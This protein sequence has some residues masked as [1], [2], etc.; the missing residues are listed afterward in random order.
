MVA[1]TMNASTSSVSSISGVTALTTPMESDFT[2]AGWTSPPWQIPASQDD[3]ITGLTLDD[4]TNTNVGF[5]GN[6]TGSVANLGLVNE[7]ITANAQ[8]ATGGLAGQL[9]GSIQNVY[10][11]GVVTDGGNTG[12][13][14]GAQSTGVIEDTISTASL[15]ASDGTAGGLVGFQLGGTVEYS[16]AT[17]NVSGPAAANGGLLGEQDGSN[18]H[19]SDSYATGNVSGGRVNGGVVGDQYT[20]GSIDNVYATGTVSGPSSGGIAGYQD[21]YQTGIQNAVYR[22]QSTL[23][24]IGTPDCEP[25]NGTL[26]SATTSQMQLAYTSSS[27]P[28]HSW[29]TDVNWTHVPGVNDGLPLLVNDQMATLAPNNVSVI[30]GQ[31][32]TIPVGVVYPVGQTAAGSLEAAPIPGVTVSL[33]ASDGNWADSTVTTTSTGTTDVWS[34][35]PTEG[36]AI[37]SAMTGQSGFGATAIIT[38]SAAPPAPVWTPPALTP[39]PVTVGGV[40]GDVIGNW[41]YNPAVAMDNGTYFGYIE[42]RAAIEAGA[43]FSGEGTDSAY[44]SAILDGSGVRAS[45]TRVRGPTRAVCGALPKAWHHPDLGQ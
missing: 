43:T 24:S 5:F 4:S 27:S 12:G 26:T 37:L 1:G 42:E 29:M 2:D 41:G 40:S 10:T 36:T 17:G 23:P 9:S 45:A 18:A 33:S 19:V 21:V 44:L 13:I 7:A 28:F 3:T 30:V 14:I 22:Q 35:P 20:Q 39:E 6:V 16:L 34:A 8:A 25:S 32:M 11:T 38:V 31:S 15:T